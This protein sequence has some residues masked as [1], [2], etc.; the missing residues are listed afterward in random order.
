MFNSLKR[1]I[2][3]KNELGLKN[4]ADTDQPMSADFDVKYR[5]QA[6]C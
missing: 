3:L 2:I 5:L 6:Y 4:D 1:S